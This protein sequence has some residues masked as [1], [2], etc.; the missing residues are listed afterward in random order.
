MIYD[1]AVNRTQLAE[2]REHAN[3]CP[4]VTLH[5][6]K[7]MEF[8]QANNTNNELSLYPA[9]LDLLKNFVLPSEQQTPQMGAQQQVGPG[10][11]MVG[12]ASFK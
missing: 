10:Q 8:F 1:S 6:N 4:T 7:F 3:A 2:K 9:V 5:I 12:Q 11:V